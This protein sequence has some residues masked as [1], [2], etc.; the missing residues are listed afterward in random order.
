[1]WNKNDVEQMDLLGQRASR[2]ARFGYPDTQNRIPLS[3]KCP[4]AIQSHL[5]D[6]L[7]PRGFGPVPSPAPRAP[8]IHTCPLDVVHP[9]D[10]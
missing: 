1:M 4:A 5:A 2:S 8:D 10:N 7:L 6:T 9:P 3:V